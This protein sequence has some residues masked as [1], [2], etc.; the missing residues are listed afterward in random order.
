LKKRT[1]NLDMDAL[2]TFMAG[3]ERGSFAKAAER[4]GRSPAAVSQQLR[5][6]E[7]QFGAALLEKRGRS[8][9]PT[10]AGEVALAYARR[11]LALN[12]EALAAV[13]GVSQEGHIR[14]GLVQDFA[15]GVLPDVLGR[16]SRAHPGVLL[17]AVVDGSRVLLE[18]LEAGIL[19]LALVWGE[20]EQPNRQALGTAPMRWMGRPGFAVPLDQPV[21]LVVLRTPCRFR[22]AGCAALDAAGIPWRIVF[23]SP[24]LGAA[25]AAVAAGLGVTPRVVLGLPRGLGPVAPLDRAAPLP[26]IGAWLAGASSP[27]VLLLRTEV[28]GLVAEALG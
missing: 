4:I 10:A 15:E 27:V 26:P 25:W 8:L 23:T 22:E 14:F 21:P 17:D 28:A 1:I 5:K 3:V 20:P 12:D 2:R 18:G 24:S 6:L 16:F 19:D 11:L 7:T 9:A 13:G